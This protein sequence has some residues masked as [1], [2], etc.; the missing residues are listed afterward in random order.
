MGDGLY[1]EIYLR[2]GKTDEALAY[3]E[4]MADRMTR[5]MEPPNPLL[6][7]PE[8]APGPEKLGW[9][10]EILMAVLRGLEKDAC[11]EPLRGQERFGRLVE[12]IQKQVQS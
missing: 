10:R 11:F 6:F 1:A 3:L 4:R 7:A 8:I 5:P 9:N 2:A 12:L